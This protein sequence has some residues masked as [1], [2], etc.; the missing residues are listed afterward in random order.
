MCLLNVY[1]C[2]HD[3]TIL[4]PLGHLSVN[5]VGVKKLRHPT[6][7]CSEAQKYFVNNKPQ[8]TTNLRL[9][10]CLEDGSFRQF[11]F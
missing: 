10:F 4:S 11:G 3:K 7:L 6:R 9:G 5:F 8:A 1:T 2:R